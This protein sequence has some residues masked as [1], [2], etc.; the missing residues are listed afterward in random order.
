MEKSQGSRKLNTGKEVVRI[1]IRKIWQGQ[2]GRKRER[3]REGESTREGDGR[4]RTG[5]VK[6]FGDLSG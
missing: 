1:L 6:S 2:S 3:E 4:G 5:S